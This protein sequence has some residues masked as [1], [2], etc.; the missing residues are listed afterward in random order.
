MRDYE[1]KLAEKDKK[2]KSLSSETREA[3][4]STNDGCSSSAMDQGSETSATSDVPVCIL[5]S[6]TGSSLTG[7]T[8]LCPWA[9]TLILA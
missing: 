6:I 8:V 1:K 3:A 4:G 5:Q 7:I 9:R 2:V